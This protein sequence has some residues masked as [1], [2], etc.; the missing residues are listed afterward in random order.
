MYTHETAHAV[1]AAQAAGNLLRKAFHKG[2]AEEVE[3]LAERHIFHV[4]HGAFPDYGYRG[5]ELGLLAEPRDKKGHLWLVDPQD[6]TKAAQKGFRGAAVSIALLREGVPVLGLVFAYSAP[7]DLGDLFSWSEGTGPVR[8]NGRETYRNWSVELHEAHVV[9]VS[10]DADR[11]AEV[12]AELV[13]PMRFRTIPGIAYRLALVAAGDGD[14]AVSLNGPTGWD[15]AGGHALLIGSGGDL[16]D[17]RGNPIRYDRTG[18]IV[19]GPSRSCFG[20][21][22]ELAMALKDRAWQRVFEKF[23]NIRAADCLSYLNPGETVEHA[24]ILSRAQGCLLGQLS[25]DALGSLVESRSAE[26]IAREYLDGPRRLVNGGSWDTIAGQPTDDSEM[27]LSLAR[28]IILTGRY[29][30]ESAAG[31][32]AQWTGSHPFDMGTATRT[33][34]LPAR[35]AAQKHRSAA[36]AAREAA[37]ADTQANGALMR[38][39]PLGIFGAAVPAP[40]LMELARIDASLTHPNPVC[41]E[42]SALFASAIAFAI[43]TGSDAPMTYEHALATARSEQTPESLFE[44]LRS[45]EASAPADFTHNQGWVLIAFQNAFYRLLHAHSL[46]EGIIATV[47]A[48]GDTDTNAAIAGALL[49]AV[50][51]RD[52]IPKQ[53][54]ERVLS[55]RPIGSLPSVRQPRPAPYWPVDALVLAE[56]LLKA[57]LATVGLSQFPDAAEEESESSFPTVGSRGLH[58][59]G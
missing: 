7:D 30:E 49:G 26:S 21:C 23:S 34:L 58:T 22:R 9:L 42:A 29:H 38:I 48:G 47:R 36:G 18:E 2:R 52:A 28:S 45:A 17:S 59:N 1:K 5:E 51:G 32:Y 15:I 53:W 57:G 43:R 56:K 4:L 14:L 6:G 12:N 41:R 16:F 10:Q 44:A 37:L 50:H 19:G 35:H 3:E 33:A 54:A 8:R 39:S 20:G 31:A 40:D 46:E 24:G 55:C 13:S 11:K 27:A 25:G